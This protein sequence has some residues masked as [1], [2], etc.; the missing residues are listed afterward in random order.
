MSNQTKK[1]APLTK[2][3][4]ARLE[5]ERLQ[6]RWIIIGVIVVGALVL[7]LI[8]FGIIQQ[9][10]L[11]P[12]QPIA[13]INGEKVTTSEFQQQAKLSRYFLVQNAVQ[14]Y[15]F[16][17]QFND[18]QFTSQF[19]SQLQQIQSQLTPSLL[20]QQ[21]LDYLT[22]DRLIRQEATRRGITVPKEDVDRVYQAWFDYYPDGTP[23]ATATFEARPTSTLSSLQQT[24][25]PPT[26]TPT[27]TPE[28]TAT[29]P[30]T[31]TA[32]ASVTPAIE[33]TP[34]ATGPITPTVTPFPTPT[35]TAYTEEAFNEQA[36]NLLADLK[37]A[38]GLEEQDFRQAFIAQQYR[39]K[40]QDQVTAD[41]KPEQ[42][43][44]WARHILV[45][46]E[47]TAKDLISK[48][49]AGEDFCTLAAANSTD[50][51]N[52]DNCGDLSWFGTGQM[53]KEFE[54]AA[55]AL[56]VGAISEPVQS[57]FGW[58]IIQV[59]GH[60]NRPLTGEE[61]EQLRQ[62]RFQEFLAQLKEQAT[63]V[64]NDNWMSLVPEIPVLPEAI[65]TYIQS[66][67]SAIPTNPPVVFPTP[68]P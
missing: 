39:Q 30:L 8:V 33:L 22:E 56:E 12:N 54:D 62:T 34:T 7:G 59:L 16:A 60:E 49:Q 19:V 45:E 55:F 26:A 31:V 44:V 15:Q 42:E 61:F 3:H 47:Q 28:I 66:A 37:E 1:P 43:Q 17:Q 27:S 2:K 14:T 21:V 20:G 67:Q 58:H 9:N 53:V 6:R 65:L 50:T 51:S 5:R 64:T 48:L 32:E 29:L 10:V 36:N 68:A 23:T 25:V 13:E 4:L 41:L 57:Q 52:K 38:A 63:I 46:D 24:L 18:P 11:Q 35:A 40:L